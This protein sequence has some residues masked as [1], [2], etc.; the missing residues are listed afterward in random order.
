MPQPLR[1]ITNFLQR[2]EQRIELTQRMIDGSGEHRK[3]THWSI[4]QMRN[5]VFSAGYIKSRAS[6]DYYLSESEAR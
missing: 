4:F 2:R 6:K 5:A 3:G 1:L